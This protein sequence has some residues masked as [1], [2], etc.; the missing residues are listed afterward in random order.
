MKQPLNTIYIISPIVETGLDRLLRKLIPR[1][2]I[3]HITKP[4]PVLGGL[5]TN[6][7]VVFSDGLN[8]SPK[9]CGIPNHASFDTGHDA[10]DS[11]VWELVK[12]SARLLGIG[13][14][15]HFL[16][17]K[18]GGKIFTH[19]GG[20]RY[21]HKVTDLATGEVVHVHSAHD[22]AVL[23]NLP[24][25]R[26][27]AQADTSVCSWWENDREEVRYSSTKDYLQ[28]IEAW[29]STGV[30]GIQWRPDVA[31][32]PVEGRNLFYNYFCQTFLED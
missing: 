19:L 29:S 16:W 25:S 23:T 21:N 9:M 28:S 11:E 24:G 27:L 14:G 26:V 7:L 4:M 32:C 8:L 15:S 18:F 30:L 31:S 6:S 13:R 22:Q 10:L 3:L 12:S 2:S 5:D 1:V 17:V 20:H